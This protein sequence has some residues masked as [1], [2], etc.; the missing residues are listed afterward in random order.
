MNV[1]EVSIVHTFLSSSLSIYSSVFICTRILH[2]P[3]VPLLSIL[4][5]VILFLLIF[6]YSHLCPFALSSI[7]FLP[8]H[9]SVCSRLYSFIRV[10]ICSLGL[11]TFV[12]YPFY[13]YLLRCYKFIHQCLFSFVVTNSLLSVYNRMYLSVY[14]SSQQIPGN[15]MWMNQKN[16]DEGDKITL[17]SFIF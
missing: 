14:E 13:M 1:I 10:I 11:N 9:L 7:L 17:F 3:S 15:C 16:F 8:V 6:V 5:C 12:L 4:R 2:C